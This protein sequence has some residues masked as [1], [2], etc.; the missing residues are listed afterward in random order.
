MS[1][2]RRH[3]SREIRLGEHLGHKQYADGLVR[4]G[5]PTRHGKSCENHGGCPWCEGNRTFSDKKRR[6][7]LGD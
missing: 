3:K 2:T 4:D 5:T 7:A 6:M 1:R